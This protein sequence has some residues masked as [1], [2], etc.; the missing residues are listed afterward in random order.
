M[1][2]FDLEPLKCHNPRIKNNNDRCSTNVNI[3]SIL[4]LCHISY[5]YVIFVWLV[6]KSKSDGCD[7][8][9]QSKKIVSIML[10]KMLG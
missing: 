2:T 10:T 8:F 9:H 1:V 6:C 3:Y 4:H 7:S 5:T